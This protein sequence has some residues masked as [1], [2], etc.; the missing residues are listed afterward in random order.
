MGFSYL[1]HHGVVPRQHCHHTACLG[2]GHGRN[3]GRRRT[4]FLGGGRCFC[5]LKFGK[6]IV[7][8]PRGKTQQ[9]M[10][11][12]FLF[13]NGR[14]FFGGTGKVPSGSVGVAVRPW[15]R[16][17]HK[18]VGDG[19]QRAFTRQGSVVGNGVGFQ[20]DLGMFVF[21]SIVVPLRFGLL[22]PQVFPY[23][24]VAPLTGVF[25]STVGL[26]IV[27]VP[28]GLQRERRSEEHTS[29]PVTL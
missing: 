19:K 6:R 28:G 20:H 10:A 29:E 22:A 4:R 16:G 7:H 13:Q 27:V 11:P 8:F 14:A 25:C 17:H 1:A 18:R 12:S 2:Q 24:G 9:I 21:F 15:R 5:F 26:V 3:L 23:V